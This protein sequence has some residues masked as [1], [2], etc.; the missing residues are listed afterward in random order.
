MPTEPGWYDACYV[1]TL[2]E[3][4]YPMEGAIWSRCAGIWSKTLAAGEGGKKDI[5]LSF[6]HADLPWLKSLVSDMERIELQPEN[7]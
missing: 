1:D 7:E 3:C 5:T 2:A 6:N 4:K